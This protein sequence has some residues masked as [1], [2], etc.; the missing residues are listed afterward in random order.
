MEDTLRML[1]KV[2]P[3]HI[4]RHFAC[5]CTER[6]LTAANNTHEAAWASIEVGRRHAEGK[7]TDEELSHARDATWVPNKEAGSSSITAAWW[8]A[9]LNAH[10]AA[11]NAAGAAATSAGWIAGEGIRNAIFGAPTPPASRSEKVAARIR[12][13]NETRDLSVTA[14]LLERKW[15]I[16]HLK[17]LFDAHATARANLVQVL[18]HRSNIITPVF[19]NFYNELEDQLYAGDNK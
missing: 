9:S 18:V 10:E 13:F 3:A 2:A 15:Q 14:W 4:L 8:A 19:S 7:A 17:S 5:D 16:E 6:A 11:W 12:A 1:V